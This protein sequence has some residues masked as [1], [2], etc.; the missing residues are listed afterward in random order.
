MNEHI[1][2]SSYNVKSLHE[3]TGL[4]GCIKERVVEI[5]RYIAEH[6]AMVRVNQRF[7]D[8]TIYPLTIFLR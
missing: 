1:S 2:L 7:I 6:K 5:A 4:E 8:L 3:G